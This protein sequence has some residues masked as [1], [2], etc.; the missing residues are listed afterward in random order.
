LPY[1]QPW[2]CG[3]CGALIDVGTAERAGVRFC[4]SCG[5]ALTAPPGATPA[6]GN[7]D[8]RVED[9][10]EWIHDAAA[11]LGVGVP[12][13]IDLLEK[14]PCVVRADVPLAEAEAIRQRLLGVGARVTIV[15]HGG[16]A[17]AEIPLPAVADPVVLGR[18]AWYRGAAIEVR[19]TD[20]GQ[21][22]ARAAVDR[23]LSAVVSIPT[24][25]TPAPVY[26]SATYQ[27]WMPYHVHFNHPLTRSRRF[28]PALDDAPMVL[29]LWLAKYGITPDPARATVVLYAARDELTS[30]GEPRAGVSFTLSAPG[31]A[32][33]YDVP[34]GLSTETGATGEFGT[35]WA[36]DV[37]PG[38]LQVTAAADGAPWPPAT[39]AV[40]AGALVE[41]DFWP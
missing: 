36:F 6:T 31:V 24:G 22:L 35:A 1:L 38:P 29:P 8:V 2:Y 3:N 28:K 25:G 33:Y 15:E 11:A 17:P 18:V 5:A 10:P 27:G 34:S 41:I 20:D 4:G 26:L 40:E 32:L 30:P 23:M 19:R 16:L 9:V 13:G 21:V 12:V 14:A 39:V 7:V 37:P